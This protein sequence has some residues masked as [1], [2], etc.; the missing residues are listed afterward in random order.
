MIC[1]A[2]AAWTGWV[3]TRPTSQA[4]SYLYDDAFYY[5]IPAHSFAHGEGWT[6]DGI[7]PTSGFHPLYG[8]VA[9]LVSLFTG[10]SSALPAVMTLSTAATLLVA[11][12]LFLAR[13]S[14]LYGPGIA[15]IGMAATL[16]APQAFFQITSGLEW[17]W[18][19][20]TTMVLVAVLIRPAAASWHLSLAAFLAVLARID[21][22]IFVALFVVAVATSRFFDDRRHPIA[23]L[24]LIAFGAA[25]AVAGVL[26]TAI[27]SRL[28]TGSWIS[29]AVVVKET[30]SRTNDFLPAIAWNFIMSATGPGLLFTTAGTTFGLRS[31][32]VIG[33]FFLVAAL[34]CTSEWRNGTERRALALAS[35]MTIAAYAIAYARG[36]NFMFQHYSSPI[37][38]PVALLT[39]GALSASGRYQSVVSAGLAAVLAIVCA[40]DSWQGIPLH[41]AIARDAATLHATIPAGSRVGAWNAGIAGW[42][43]RRGIINLDGLANAGVAEYVREGALACYLVDARVTHIMDFEHMF[44]EAAAARVGHQTQEFRRLLRVRLAYDSAALYSCVDQKAAAPRDPLIGSRYALF[45]LHRGCVEN[46]CIKK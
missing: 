44:P 23:A 3:L 14:R 38:I 20:M 2:V 16:A 36:I 12:W 31:V 17:G 41:A 8:Y 45:E 15:A 33:V 30:W 42:Q 27:A 46:L 1:A 26:V 28:S 18:A 35:V 39:C 37:L 13:A 9:A 6:F 34:V 5:L 29:N 25:G 40:T 11:V 22:A 32:V 10:Y 43:T 7:N 19:V 24:R 4:Y 21:L